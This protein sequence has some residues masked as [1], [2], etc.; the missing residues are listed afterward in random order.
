MHTPAFDFDG[1]TKVPSIYAP[2]QPLIDSLATIIVLSE[3]GE[4][5]PEALRDLRARILR[6][7]R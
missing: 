2:C 4:E 6:S 7:A 5:L 1:A 3:R